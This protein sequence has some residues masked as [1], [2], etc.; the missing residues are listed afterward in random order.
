LSN[1]SAFL[2]ICFR[3]RCLELLGEIIAQNTTIRVLELPRNQIGARELRPLI[4]ALKLNRSLS[5]LSL[6][7]NHLKDEGCALLADAIAHHPR[8]RIVRLAGNAIRCQGVV[9][10]VFCRKPF[11]LAFSPCFRRFSRELI[12]FWTGCV[13]GFRRVRIGSSGSMFSPPWTWA[14]IAS[15]IEAPPP[16]PI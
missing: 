13:M 3:R 15:V 11:F 8:L 1:F 12:F 2:T 7:E 4:E 16:S 10:Y 6:V 14:R 9:A 5:E